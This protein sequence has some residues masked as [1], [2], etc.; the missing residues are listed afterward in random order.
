MP[1]FLI[2]SKLK[3]LNLQGLI[4]VNVASLLPFHI[5]NLKL[6]FDTIPK[7]I[8]EAA[9]IEG[10]PTFKI[11]YIIILPLAKPGIIVS[12]VFAFMGVW[13]EY[14]VARTILFDSNL[15]TLPVALGEVSSYWQTP[16]PV[17]AV[18]SIISS[19]PLF[20]IFISSQRYLKSGLLKGM[21]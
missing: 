2:L 17:F 1:L 13:N 14:I 12:L 19:I 11:I 4:L 3:L 6:F 20:I 5:I 16:W 18:Y 9:Y 10:A 21:R 15:Y 7:E 8:E